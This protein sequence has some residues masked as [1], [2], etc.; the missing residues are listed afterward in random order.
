MAR[1]PR[2]AFLHITTVPSFQR[3][4]VEKIGL[5]FG[6]RFLYYLLAHHRRA[7]LPTFATGSR[8]AGLTSHRS[9]QQDKGRLR[10]HH[11]RTQLQK[12]GHVSVPK[13]G[14][15]C[16]LPKSAKLH[17]SSRPLTH[18]RVE[19][20]GRRLAQNRRTCAERGAGGSASFTSPLALA[21][22]GAAGCV[23]LRFRV[24]VPERDE[25]R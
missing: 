23:V 8:A 25:R 15:A 22:R 10:A 19:V 24:S 1:A 20:K 3:C 18:M 2:A 5:G 11:H 4:G 6:I 17:E 21:A 12:M 13:S 9:L 7:Q 14:R 16:T